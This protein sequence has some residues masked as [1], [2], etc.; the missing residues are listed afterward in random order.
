MSPKKMGRPTANPKNIRLEIRLT[1]ED[2][3]ILEEC[4][5]ALNTTKTAVIQRGI[6][7]VRSQIKK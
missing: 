4:S 3:N 5:K 1:Q 6:R 7:L 2:A